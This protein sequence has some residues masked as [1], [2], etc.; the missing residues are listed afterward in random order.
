[1][2]AQASF[3][4][5]RSDMSSRAIACIAA[6][7]AAFVVAVP[8]MMPLAFP[9]SMRHVTSNARPGL[10][11]DAPPLEIAPGEEL[12]SVRRGNGQISETYGWVDRNRGIVRIPVSRAM[13]VLSKR[14]L[15][16]WPKP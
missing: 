15:P 7:L 3:D 16:G 11:S 9:A 12:P 14:G 5:E 10:S 4:Y 2:D 13:E 1:M 6:G 8:L